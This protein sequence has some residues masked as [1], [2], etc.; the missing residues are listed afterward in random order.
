MSRKR[1]K[2]KVV[3]VLREARRRTL[4]TNLNHLAKLDEFSLT[5]LKT[6]K[7]KKKRKIQMT[8]DRDPDIY[9]EHWIGD[10]IQQQRKENIRFWSQNY[11]G[12]VHKS[13]VREFEYDV[14]MLDDKSIN[15]ISFNETCVNT[16]KPGYSRKL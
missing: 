8:L 11:N 3:A 14:A 15:Y 16:N 10:S 12:M 5:K 4:P 9:D 13:D 2:G 7:E 1:G 6:T